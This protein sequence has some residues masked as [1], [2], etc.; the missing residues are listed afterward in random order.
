MSFHEPPT[1]YVDKVKL[2]VE[3]IERSIHFYEQVIGFKVLD[4]TERS[5]AF[6]ADGNHVLLEIE[7]PNNVVRELRSTAG[8]YHFALLLPKRTDLANVVRHFVNI[9]LQFGSGDHLVSEAIYLSDP[10]GNGIEIYAD[11][12]PTKWN[13]KHN[14]VAM[15]TQAV[16]FNHL[17]AEKEGD[18][19]QGLPE[20][21]VMGHIHL[22]VAE[23][24][25]NERFYIDG[26]GFQ[27]VNRLS[28]RAL[29]ISDNKYHHHI[30]FNTW[31]GEGIPE[32]SEN[33]VGLSSYTIVF[34]NRDTREKVIMNL[35]QI[36]ATVDEINGCYFT[37]DPSNI[38]IEL[39]VSSK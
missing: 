21:T 39:D 11:R 12:D 20:D 10:D 38:R 7:Q 17:L 25:R 13:W 33:A 1:T 6:T 22:Q 26:L 16:D 19:W 24:E 37:I 23:I 27:V 28:F 9:H 34:P 14:E 2:K 5:A 29:F 36:G 32:P 4:R 18:G 3:N 8:L 31:A 35:K 30:A 15:T